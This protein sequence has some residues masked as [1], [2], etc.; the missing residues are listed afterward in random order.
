MDLSAKDQA[1]KL[2]DHLPTRMSL[3]KRATLEEQSAAWDEL[4]CYYDPFV[5]KILLRL[6]VSATDLNDVKQQVFLR[7]WKGLHNYKKLNTGS[8]VRNWLA[9]LI[10]RTSINWYHAHKHQKEEVELNIEVYDQQKIESPQINK[11]IEKEWQQYIVDLALEQLKKVFSGHAF[12]VLALSMEGESGD[13]IANTLNIRK[14]SVYVLRNRVKARLS[15]EIKRLRY[16]LE[17]QGINA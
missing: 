13:E 9:T 16:N 11:L 17:G 15:E 5:Q 4:I 10:R 7:L 6:G 2:T 14:E 3:L 12:E 8:R 1:N